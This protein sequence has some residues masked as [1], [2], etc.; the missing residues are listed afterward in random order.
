MM[1]SKGDIFSQTCPFL[2]MS[3]RITLA[4]ATLTAL[5]EPSVLD[6]LRSAATRLILFFLLFYPGIVNLQHYISF[7][8]TT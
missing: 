3:T 4:E 5:L 6:G 7:K 1:V 8:C 2:S